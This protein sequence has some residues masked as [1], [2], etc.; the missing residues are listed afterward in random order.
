MEEKTVEMMV[1]D[2]PLPP[3][4]GPAFVPEAVEALN[5]AIVETLSEM[6]V[7]LGM[8]SLEQVAVLQVLY[9]KAAL[10]GWDAAMHNGPTAQRRAVSAATAAK[11]TAA[12]EN[13]AKVVA[14]FERAAATGSE[15][16]ID[17]IAKE[18]GVSRATA[19]RA[20]MNRK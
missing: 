8:P 19:Y 5:E 20:L 3:W 18:C 12:D 10:W 11:K 17:A 6:Y 14:A 13:R 15:P 16:N 1:S 2:A 9:A 4:V 7:E